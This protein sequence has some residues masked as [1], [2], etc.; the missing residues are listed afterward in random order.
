MDDRKMIEEAAAL[1]PGMT[2]PAPL[3]KR[4]VNQ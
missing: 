2:I 3:F 1:L 4:Y